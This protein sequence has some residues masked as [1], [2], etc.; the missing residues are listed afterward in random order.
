MV[1]RAGSLT[2]EVKRK[3]CIG[4]VAIT[5]SHGIYIN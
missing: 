4:A 1:T 3:M 5:M 2:K